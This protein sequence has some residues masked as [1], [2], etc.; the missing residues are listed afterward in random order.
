MF[1]GFGGS[2]VFFLLRFAL[3]VLYCAWLRPR[4][5]GSPAPYGCEAGGRREVDFLVRITMDVSTGLKMAS[6][7]RKAG[8]STGTIAKA[9]KMGQ[10]MGVSAAMVVEITR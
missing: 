4:S 7:A 9:G 6:A 5:P 2:W 10:K 3:A 1:L 8:V